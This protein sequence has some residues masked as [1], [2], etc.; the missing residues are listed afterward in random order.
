[1]L[2]SFLKKPTAQF[3]SKNLTIQFPP[4]Y[5]FFF[6]IIWRFQKKFVTLPQTAEYDIVCLSDNNAKHINI[7]TKSIKPNEYETKIY[8]SAILDAHVHLGCK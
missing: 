7:I 6:R 5:F 4:L 1:M 2:I 3:L 8:L